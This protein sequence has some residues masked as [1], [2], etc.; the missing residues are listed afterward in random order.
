MLLSKKK[1]EDN[2]KI[3]L[4]V[5]TNM[6]AEL[7]IP[8]SLVSTPT[9]LKDEKEKFLNSDTYNPQFKYRIVK[10]KNDAILKDLLEVEEIIDVDPSS[11]ESF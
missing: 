8:L 2:K 1:K 6:L 9:N 5:A 7:R 11:D 4:E 10:N 3:T